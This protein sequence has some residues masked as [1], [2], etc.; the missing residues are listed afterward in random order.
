MGCLAQ[1]QGVD[2]WAQIF[3]SVSN[4]QV[5]RTLDSTPQLSIHEG[6]LGAVGGWPFFGL[7]LL[8]S[9]E[10]ERSLYSAPSHVPWTVGDDQSL[11]LCTEIHVT[12]ITSSTVIRYTCVF[13]S[14]V[15]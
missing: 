7:I 14:Q 2:V 12:F 8:D 1:E 13:A 4:D 6:L 5:L 11:G 3:T 10:K 15:I 9:S